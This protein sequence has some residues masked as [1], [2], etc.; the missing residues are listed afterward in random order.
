MINN[1]PNKLTEWL[2]Q[3][4]YQERNGELLSKLELRYDGA[5]GSSTGPIETYEFDDDT[6]RTN[7]DEQS[8]VI[9]QRAQDDADGK[10]SE[11]VTYK[12]YAFFGG[13]ELSVSQSTPGKFQSSGI[14][15]MNRD[16]YGNYSSGPSGGGGGSGDK[17]F[18]KLQ[19]KHNEYLVGALVANTVHFQRHAENMLTKAHSRIEQLE[20]ERI[21]VV[22][23]IE[24]MHNQAQDRQISLKRE[25]AK[26]ER[27]T[28]MWDHAKIL[29][30]TVVNKLS[31][32]NLLPVKETPRDEII[33]AIMGSLSSKQIESLKEILSPGQMVGFA[34]LY[35]EEAKKND[36]R[37]AAKEKRERDMEGDT[38][39]GNGAAH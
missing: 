28:E 39:N 6:P 2:K 37:K 12:V 30:P 9:M 17:E 18:S 25:G 10:M 33:H 23:T 36:E 38:Q 29:F 32:K 20:H 7:E 11:Y 16:G 5:E 14:E 8:Q 22:K 26:L 21:D 27:Q 31:G 3:I 24:D 1:W 13:N 19:M 35:E 34:E 4:L 15:V